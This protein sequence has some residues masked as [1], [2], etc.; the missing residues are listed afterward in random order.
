MTLKERTVLI[1][2]GNSG[3]GK[4]TALGLALLGAN[5]VIVCRNRKKGEG[6]VNDI[7][8]QSGNKNVELIVSD[9]QSQKQVRHAAEEFSENNSQLHVLVNNAGTIVPHYEQTEDGIEK[10]MAINYLAPFL[11]TNLLLGTIRKSAPARIVNVTSAT[12]FSA[13]LDLS[14][15]AHETRVGSFGL[16][17][18]SRSKLALVL[19]TYELARREKNSCITANCLHPGAVRTH[20]WSHAGAASPLSIFA[21][22]FLRSAKHGA[23]TSIYLS[24]SPEV[25]RVSGRYFVDMVEHGSSNE[26]Y[27]QLLAGKLWTTSLDLCGMAGC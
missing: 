5:I 14:N 3:I 4:E 9:L 26:T 15:F 27:D 25:E 8:R 6:A 17:A 12:H 22:L 11:L 10:T 7:R 2:G 13:T 1:T 20:I 19:F 21:S 23:R 16:E 24:S 18:Y